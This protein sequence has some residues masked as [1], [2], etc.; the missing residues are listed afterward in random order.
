MFLVSNCQVVIICFQVFQVSVID[1]PS[2]RDDVLLAFFRYDDL[3]PLLVLTWSGAVRQFVL[4][5]DN[6]RKF[7]PFSYQVQP[8]SAAS[9]PFNHTGHLLL[10]DRKARPHVLSFHTHLVP[11]PDPVYINTMKTS[12]MMS[13]MKDRIA[14][15]ESLVQRLNQ[16]LAAAVK[17]VGHN[18]LNHKY[19]FSDLTSLGQSILRKIRNL[20]SILMQGSPLTMQDLK[21]R[22]ADLKEAV[23]RLR[24]A[25]G[26][27]DKELKQ[28]AFKNQ[29]TVMTGQNKLA[30][31]DAVA[32]NASAA[33]VDFVADVPVQQVLNSIFLPR[34]SPQPVLA[35]KF[36]TDLRVIGHVNAI[37]NDIDLANAV[38]IDRVN[39]ITSKTAIS[40]ID[41]RGNLNINRI[42]GLNLLTDL[43]RIDVPA[44]FEIHSP[45]H[46]SGLL[47]AD[48]LQAP[49]IDGVDVSKF[50]T[51]SLLTTGDHT[52]I[53]PIILNGKV[54][55]RTNGKLR[56]LNQQPLDQLAADIVRI[57]QSCIIP[58]ARIFAAAHLSIKGGLT[59]NGT[60]D[61]L[62]VPLDLFLTST[63]QQITAPVR[64]VGHQNFAQVD[65][66][67]LVDGL[68]LPEHVVTLTKDDFAPGLVLAKGADIFSSVTAGKVDGVDLK[69]LNLMSVKASEGK[70]LNPVFDG[71]VFVNHMLHVTGELLCN[72]YFVMNV[73]FVPNNKV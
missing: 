24:A 54:L 13:N 67:K 65:V 59:V 36:F 17:P 66:D 7:I 71:P 56:L 49:L 29:M 64:L 10:M 57:D 52:V 3:N 26:V 12:V 31:A 4:A 25:Y 73:F 34:Q 23:A 28:V 27:I 45:V 70:L 2:C 8:Q 60:I 16:L 30:A 15:Q 18:V 61:G 39:R 63:P 50:A 38:T 33:I 37:I 11:V 32:I 5:F 20:R 21:I 62:R 40:V 42:A 68:K 22:S 48:H 51:G 72:L 19:S 1:A 53:T 46:F 9:F 6:V 44:I 14:N 35:R 43:I 55:I 47:M 69:L 58:G 41:V